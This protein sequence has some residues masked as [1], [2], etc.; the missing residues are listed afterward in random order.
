VFIQMVL[1]ACSQQDD[2]RML[3]DEWCG[4]MRGRYGWL[5]GTY[6][7]TDDGQFVGVCRFDGPGSAREWAGDAEAGM[8]WA[9]AEEVFD[10]APEIHES[11][12]VTLMLDGGSDHAGFVQVMRGRVTNLDALKRIMSDHEMTSML[13]QA[14]PEIIGATLAIEDDGTFTETVAFTDEATARRGEQSDAYSDQADEFTS[15]MEDV[16]YYDLHHPWF[17][18]G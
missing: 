13:H 14:R 8:W 7:F 16:R 9:A 2:M 15:T 1:G 17:G 12:D 6:G 11:D 4:Q 10:G 3:V 5:G 18:S